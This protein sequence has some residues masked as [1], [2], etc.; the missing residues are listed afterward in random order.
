MPTEGALIPEP[1]AQFHNSYVE[2]KTEQTNMNERA[3]PRLSGPQR[4]EKNCRNNRYGF[5][6]LCALYVVC[7]LKRKYASVH[8]ILPEL[9]SV[10]LFSPI[11]LSRQRL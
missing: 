7:L 8:E 11:S 3:R 4:Y 2:M 1:R 10:A 5:L 6:S 9:L